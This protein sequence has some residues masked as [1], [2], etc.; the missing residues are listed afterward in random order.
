MS[1]LLERNDEILTYTLKLYVL[2]RA[3]LSTVTGFLPNTVI[4]VGNRASLEVLVCRRGEGAYT[5]P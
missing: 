2:E 1:Q 5:L 3:T 4:S